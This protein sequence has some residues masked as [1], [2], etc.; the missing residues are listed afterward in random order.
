MRSQRW[1]AMSVLGAACAQPATPLPTR[2]PT[3]DIALAPTAPEPSAAPSCS[4]TLDTEQ[5]LSDLRTVRGD[6]ARYNELLKGA[7]FAPLESLDGIPEETSWSLE[8]AKLQDVQL[9]AEGQQVLLSLR[10]ELGMFRS[11]MRVAVLQRVGKA[12]CPVSLELSR[13]IEGFSCLSDGEPPFSIEGQRV[14]SAGWD[15]LLVSVRSGS[16]DGYS[17]GRGAHHEVELWGFVGSDFKR[18]YQADTFD[19]WYTSPV[20]PLRTLER[21]L[22]FIGEA[23]KS[24]LVTTDVT[25]DRTLGQDPDQECEEAHAEQRLTY[26]NGQYE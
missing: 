11:A 15:T 19:A 17:M 14:V 13:D 6:D 18:L 8:E 1:L 26:Q 9:K 2:T 22:Q 25:C 20:P 4:P 23:P 24:L 10:F 16:C 7:G 21:K 12:L 3:A 5:L